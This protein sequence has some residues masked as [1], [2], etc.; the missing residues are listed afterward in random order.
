MNILILVST[1]N[2]GGA[3]KQAVLDA[4][5]LSLGHTVYLASFKGGPLQEQVLDN[6]TIRQFEKT[7]Y[8]STAFRILNFVKKHN[9]QI[10]HAHLFAS[11]VISTLASLFTRISVVWHF[12]AHRYENPTKGKLIL[13]W[14]SK[15]RTVKRLLFVNTELMEY[16]LK[17]DFGFP[18]HKCE[19]MY[20]S[21]QQLKTIKLPKSDHMLKIG[22]I[23]R[24]VELKRVEYLVE[25]AKWLKANNF[26][27]FEIIIVGDGPEKGRLEQM[28]I[29]NRVQENVIF[30]GFQIDTAKYYSQF[31]IFI[32]PSREECLSIALIDAGVWAIPSIAF[33]VGGN[34]EII[35]NEVTGYIVKSKEELFEKVQFLIDNPSICNQMG[36]EAQNFCI[37]LFGEDTHRGALNSLYAEIV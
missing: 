27:N 4:N 13:R 15:L 29:E 9:I 36:N 14:L 17:E 10:I 25:L 11:S 30:A 23:G 2:F 22:F 26:N 18:S 32:L 3:E 34:D 33:Q 16:Y 8:I 28:S 5:M 1:L 35:K 7:N 20:N 19:I 12:H 24:L 21:T 37:S 31:D 6:V